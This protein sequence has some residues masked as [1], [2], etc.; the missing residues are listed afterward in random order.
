MALT[1]SITA[2]D[3]PSS[4]KLIPYLGRKD[5]QRKADLSGSKEQ[6]ITQL[7]QNQEFG[8]LISKSI[9]NKP[10]SDGLGPCEPQSSP[11]NSQ[12]G[13]PDLPPVE[14]S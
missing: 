10:K 12:M 5:A 3:K 8:Y 14:A 2:L 6:E 9:G 4:V 1:P 11:G 7:E 13:F